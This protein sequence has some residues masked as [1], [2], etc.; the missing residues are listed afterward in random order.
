MQE[1]CPRLN[2]TLRKKMKVLY[3]QMLND[4]ASLKPH[5]I[6]LLLRC[7]VRPNLIWLSGQGSA[8]S[9]VMNSLAGAIW[10][11][12]GSRRLCVRWE[13]SCPSPWRH[14]GLSK[15][16][17]TAQVYEGL[18]KK[19]WIQCHYIRTLQLLLGV[20]LMRAAVVY[21][22]ICLSCHFANKMFQ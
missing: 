10:Q 20:D 16:L 19:T 11:F 5:V 4:K 8:L 15:Q 2:P 14:L 3:L 7:R 17:R 1:T 9:L 6:S 18:V 21:T 22:E 12:K 13:M